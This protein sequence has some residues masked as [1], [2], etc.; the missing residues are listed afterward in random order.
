MAGPEYTDDST[1]QNNDE[2]WRRIPPWHLVPDEKL[3]QR[4]ISSA[5]FDDSPDGSPMSVVLANESRGPNSVLRGHEEG[6][7]LAS[8]TAGLARECSQG[9]AR[10][11]LTEEPAHAVVFGRKTDRVRRRFAKEAK[12]IIPPKEQNT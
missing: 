10:K 5:A 11:P 2:L 7:T 6:F 1:I 9:V 3:S 12:W 4:R 8:I